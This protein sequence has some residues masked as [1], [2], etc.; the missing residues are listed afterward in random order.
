MAES[1]R[2]ILQDMRDALSPSST[3][4]ANVKGEGRTLT[5]LQGFTDFKSVSIYSPGGTDYTLTFTDG[6]TVTITGGA[7]VSINAESG[8]IDYVSVDPLAGSVIVILTKPI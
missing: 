8:I 6:D 4:A 2:D 3:A 5:S 7:A 1:E